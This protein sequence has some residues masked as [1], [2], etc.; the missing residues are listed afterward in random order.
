MPIEWPTEPTSSDMTVDIP[1]NFPSRPVGPPTIL[2]AS[3]P[4]NV[5]INW[6]VPSPHNMMLGGSFRLRAYVECLGPGQEMQL[7]ETIIVPVVPGQTDY[8]AT[9]NVPANTLRGEGDSFEGDLVSGVYKMVVV[10]QHMN[11]GPTWISGY[12]EESIRMF[13]SP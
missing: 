12:A 3:Q 2:V 10:L 9:I 7:G 1:D 11:S 4:C 13:R 8:T 6:T 5:N